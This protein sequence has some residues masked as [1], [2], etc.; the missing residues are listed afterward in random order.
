[1]IRCKICIVPNSRE[2]INSTP[3]SNYVISQKLSGLLFAF[4]H[5]RF[6]R[7][8]LLHCL[9]LSQKQR[10]LIMLKVDFDA[11]AVTLLQELLEAKLTVEVP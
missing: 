7:K 1:M 5:I 2:S 6:S 10:S 4:V 3:A 9:T 11:I 8:R